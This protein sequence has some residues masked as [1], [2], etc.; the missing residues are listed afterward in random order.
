MTMYAAVDIGG[1]A[2]KFGVVSEDGSLKGTGSVPSFPDGP[3]DL[4]VQRIEQ[5]IEPLCRAYPVKAIGISTAGQVDPETGEVTYA[6]EA[7]PGYTGTPLKAIIEARFGVPVAVENDVNCM[8]LGEYW[9]GAAAGHDD[10]LCL[11]LGTG[12]GGAILLDGTIHHGAASSAG[13]FGHMP[14]YPGGRACA[15]GNKGCFEAYASSKALHETLVATDA[16]AYPDLKTAFQRASD[17]DALA[18]SIIDDW[19]KELALGLQGIIHA[20]NPSLVLIGGGITAQ[21]D[22]L[23]QRIDRAVSNRLMPRFRQSVT[24]AFATHGNDANL[25]GA[26]HP[27]LHRDI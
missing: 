12:I 24:M 27:L 19:V 14:L 16:D 8:A 7:I 11:A 23:L 18:E 6:T 9:L 10:V 17:G 20:M 1:T 13:E 5:V 3:D 25:L 21:G 22:P 15:C 2:I 26:V 4:I